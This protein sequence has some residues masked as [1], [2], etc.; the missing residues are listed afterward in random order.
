[1]NEM[2]WED[3]GK[4]FHGGSD[5][6]EMGSKPLQRLQER[7]FPADIRLA[8]LYLDYLFIYG[9]PSFLSVLFVLGNSSNVEC[10][11]L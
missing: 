11:S 10:L 7:I 3:L 1:M 9:E 6:P 2:F 4:A 8:S 5:S